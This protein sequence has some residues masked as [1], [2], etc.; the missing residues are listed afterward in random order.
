MILL[1]IIL[2]VYFI[3]GAYVINIED[4]K[5]KVT[6]WVSLSIDKKTALY[7]DSFGIEY[8]VPAKPEINEL[9]TIYLECKIMNLLNLCVDFIV[10]PL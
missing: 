9:L 7:F 6:N 5:S 3:Y 4:K 8:I 2:C 1:K 10:S